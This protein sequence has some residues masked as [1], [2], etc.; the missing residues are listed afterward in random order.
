MDQFG[1]QFQLIIKYDEVIGNND[2]KD[3]AAISLLLKNDELKFNNE[4]TSLNIF[5]Y[6]SD[7]LYEN[8]IRKI[9]QITSFTF[10]KE[11][12]E[13]VRALSEL[14]K[15]H[16]L[17][18]FKSKMGNLYVKGRSFEFLIS[19]SSCPDA[20]L[21]FYKDQFDKVD[22][23]NCSVSMGS[24]RMLF[25]SM[26]TNSEAIVSRVEGNENYEETNNDPFV[27]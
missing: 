16:K 3:Y 22:V 5:K 1:D 15:E 24:D 2:Q 8:T 25:S 21:T 19:S 9:D 26:D 10:S 18:E 23:E 17:I 6:I 7:E 14:D 13:R 11:T 20:S 4:C 12:I 27:S